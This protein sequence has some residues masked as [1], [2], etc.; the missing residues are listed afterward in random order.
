MASYFPEA[1]N[2]NGSNSN[3]C[4][5]VAGPSSSGSGDLF[6]LSDRSRSHV[7]T[8]FP[9]TSTTG[10]HLGLERDDNSHSAFWALRHCS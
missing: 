10:R 3:M 2:L 7:L 6:E 5:V 9:T 4:S 1:G 8:I